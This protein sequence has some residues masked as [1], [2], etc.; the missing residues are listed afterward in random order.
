MKRI[1][2]IVFAL[3]AATPAIAHKARHVVVRRSCP[4]VCNTSQ[5]APRP[6]LFASMTPLSGLQRPDRNALGRRERVHSIRGDVTIVEHPHGCP[7]IAFC[8]CGAAVRVFGSPR[9]ELWLA[10]SWFKFPR[11]MAA[12]GMVA[13][14]THHVFVLEH[15]AEGGAWV[16]YDANSGGHQTRIHTRSLAGYVIV[17]PHG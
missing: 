13:V 12:P 2:I 17:N 16:V 5:N 7:H 14:R 6:S 4:F 1:T 10:R 15:P 11:A 8:A 9:R 3:L